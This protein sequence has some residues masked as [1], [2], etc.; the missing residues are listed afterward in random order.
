MKEALGPRL[1][2]MIKKLEDVQQGGKTSLL[3]P[4]APAS[5]GDN[6]QVQSRTLC[7]PVYIGD[8]DIPLNPSV[9][10]KFATTLAKSEFELEKTL[11]DLALQ[12]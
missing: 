1:D 7:R 9:F 5:G 11:L 12:P 4:D 10:G 8:E 2:V 3:K 6:S